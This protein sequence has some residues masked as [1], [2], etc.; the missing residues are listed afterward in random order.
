MQRAL[1]R[2]A[3]LEQAQATPLPG[4]ALDAFVGKPRVV[5][6]F[7]LR[8]LTAGHVLVLQALDSPVLRPRTSEN[9]GAID[10]ADAFELLFVLT[11]DP[12]KLRGLLAQGRQAFRDAALAAT[13][14]RLPPDSALIQSLMAEL[15]EHINEAFSTRVEVGPSEKAEKG[16][17]VFTPG[18]LPGKQTA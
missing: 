16:E 18:R 4:P 1:A 6:G 12:R 17:Q 5:F 10:P 15:V 2:R 14:D 13:A 9:A 3:A 11:E 8:P 7:T